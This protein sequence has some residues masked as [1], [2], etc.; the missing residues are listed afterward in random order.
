MKCEDN[1]PGVVA[2]C[3]TRDTAHGVWNGRRE[4]HQ[5]DIRA[6]LI[7]R[8]G[9]QVVE[10]GQ[11]W[12]WGYKGVNGGKHGCW[13]RTSGMHFKVCA[14]LHYGRHLAAVGLNASL[15]LCY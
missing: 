5:V 3:K 13:N 12:G 11:G 10:G 1:K 2:I 7:Q 15:S 14:M 4:R 8:R 6:I 9:S